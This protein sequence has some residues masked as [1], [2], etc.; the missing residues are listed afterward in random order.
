MPI[1][2]LPF[3]EK[4]SVGYTLQASQWHQC[5]MLLDIDEMSELLI[6]LE[7][8]SMV[9]VSGVIALNESVLPR[10]H[11]LECYRGYVSALKA[12]RFPDEAVIRGPF[13]S[14]LTRDHDALYT[15]PLKTEGQCLIK[16]KR[17][18]VQLQN[19][20]LHY[21][22]ADGKFRSMVFGNESIFWG[23][24]FSFPRLFQDERFQVFTVKEGD[25]F[26]NAALFKQIQLWLRHNTRATPF[27]VNGKRSFS[28]A[29]L[30]NSCFSWIN[31]HPQLSVKGVRVVS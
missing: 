22:S 31:N 2:N 29:R 4:Q 9:Q 27:E 3:P 1:D 26:P 21:S 5:P 15:V 30:G 8:F 19:H 24:Q 28:P 11:F 17:P 23:I 25:L 10:E 20:R 13:S 6:A 12:G 16:V 14:I 18:V 7:P